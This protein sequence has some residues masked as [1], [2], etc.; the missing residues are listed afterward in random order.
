VDGSSG[1]NAE[2][3]WPE[4]EA[5]LFLRKRTP[6]INITIHDLSAL[7]GSGVAA[8]ASVSSFYIAHRRQDGY[9]APTA[10]DRA[11]AAGLA[12]AAT[13]RCPG[14]NDVTCDPSASLH[15]LIRPGRRPAAT[16]GAAPE[17]EHTDGK[18]D[19]TTCVL[20]A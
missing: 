13:G 6:T 3:H 14:C 16:N 4:D 20:N 12:V 11:Q 8:M 7:T 19:F 1:F 15:G 18:L 9:A 2:L 10:Q 17:C 5:L